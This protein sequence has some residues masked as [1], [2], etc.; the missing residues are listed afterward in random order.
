MDCNLTELGYSFSFFQVLL[1]GVLGSFCVR[2][3]VLSLN[4]NTA[5]TSKRKNRHGVVNFVEWNNCRTL[6]S[7]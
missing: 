4:F 1:H 6:L 7:D 5:L 2:Q 3:K